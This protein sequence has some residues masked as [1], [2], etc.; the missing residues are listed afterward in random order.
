MGVT[1]MG[2]GMN[3]ELQYQVDIHLWML[4]LWVWNDELQYRANTYLSML[5]PWERN[6]ELQY[7]VN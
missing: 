7:R 3:Y 1:A 5:R 6:D 4:R 2:I